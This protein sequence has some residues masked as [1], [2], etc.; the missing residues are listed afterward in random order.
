MDNVFNFANLNEGRM[1]KLITANRLSLSTFT[2]I[3]L[4]S[5]LYYVF[6]LSSLNSNDT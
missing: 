1:Q 3:T 5:T 2:Q 4:D 6:L